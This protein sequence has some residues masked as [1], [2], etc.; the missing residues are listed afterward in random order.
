MRSTDGDEFLDTDGDG[1]GD[2]ADEDID[3]DGVN[4]DLDPAHD[5]LVSLDMDGDGIA[6]MR[7]TTSTEMASITIDAPLT[8]RSKIRMA[9]AS[10]TRLMVTWAVTASNPI[11]DDLDGDGVENDT[12]AFPLD[13]DEFID[14][15]G[16]GIGDSGD[17][18]DDNDGIETKTTPFPR[19]GGE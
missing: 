19:S 16:D 3:G 15:D 8:R 2:N 9:T 14:S 1:V 13:D 7:M 4:N 5:P 17:L 10:R 11:D 6:E 12:D 18:D